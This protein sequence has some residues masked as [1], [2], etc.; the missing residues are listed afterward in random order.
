MLARLHAESSKNIYSLHG[1]LAF[2]LPDW[3]QVCHWLMVVSNCSPGS[4]LFH[5]LRLIF[6]KSSLALIFLETLLLTRYRSSHISSFS[7]AFI[8]SLVSR[9]ELL[10]F[11]PL[12]V[13]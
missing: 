3:G 5:A 2:I 13:R 7:I 9:M 4:A 6:S 12:T 8:N 1:L 11:C 10:E